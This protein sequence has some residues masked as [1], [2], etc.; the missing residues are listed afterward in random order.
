MG[1]N[2]GFHFLRPTVPVN[3][4]AS[5]PKVVQSVGQAHVPNSSGA[6]NLA[7][8]V[9]CDWDISAGTYGLF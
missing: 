5:E 4:P 2:T 1:C 9:A 7:V 8:N 3:V 6:F